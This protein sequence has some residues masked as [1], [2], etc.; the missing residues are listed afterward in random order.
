MKK[1]I[2]F[3]L[4]VLMIASVLCGCSQEHTV[5]VSKNGKTKIGLISIVPAE[6]IDEMGTDDESTEELEDMELKT[7]NGEKCYVGEDTQNF[8][9]TTK[10]TKYMLDAYGEDA[11]GYFKTFKVTTKTFNATVTDGLAE[12]MEL[13]GTPYDIKLT[14]TLPYTIT[15]TNGTLSADKKT[16]SFDVLK[17]DK[18]YAYT[19]KS[20]KSAKIYFKK[21]YLK[22]NDTAYLSWNSVKGAQK[23]VVQYKASGDKSWKKTTTKK[24]EKLVKN[25]KAGKKYTFKVTAV[26]KSKKYTSINTYVTPLKKVTATV[27]SKTSKSV[28]LSWKKN[29]DADGYI[30]YQKTTK[31]GS[32]KKVKT[33]KDPYNASCTVKNLKSNK[34]YYFKVVSFSKENGKTIKS[35]GATVTTKTK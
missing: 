10:A 34:K 23:Y 8:S 14:I 2:S 21:D 27:K 18:L 1:I 29:T 3:I 22:T 15:K 13:T 12:S 35:S 11:G 19:V 4:V 7:I 17:N 16:V 5:K 25:L 33:I 31:S 30:V 26:T 32:W 9:S 28:K 24:T 6:L 20:A